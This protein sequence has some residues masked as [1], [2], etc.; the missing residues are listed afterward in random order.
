LSA[1]IYSIADRSPLALHDCCH[2]WLQTAEARRTAGD[3]FGNRKPAAARIAEGRTLICSLRHDHIDVEFKNRW[4]KIWPEL[5]GLFE[6]RFC[7]VS[8]AAV[9]FRRFGI[10]C[11]LFVIPGNES[12][13]PGQVRAPPGRR[14]TLSLV[15]V[16]AT[17]ST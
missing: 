15:V 10:S 7:D 16:T 4:E 3:R 1:V 2:L 14:N 13:G 9:G 5:I 12:F 17:C 8:P 11:A 6:C